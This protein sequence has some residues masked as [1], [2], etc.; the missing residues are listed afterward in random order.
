MILFV[1]GVWPWDVVL[2]H[3]SFRVLPHQVETPPE[4]LHCRRFPH[5]VLV[6][7]ELGIETRI[8]RQ[9]CFLLKPFRTPLPLS[10]PRHDSLELEP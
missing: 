4:P 7:L 1:E 5:F 8:P 9:G 10:P 6:A 2:L 3:F